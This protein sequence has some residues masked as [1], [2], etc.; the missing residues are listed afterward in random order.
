MT[1]TSAAN[2]LGLLVARTRA[3]G[4]AARD[5]GLAEIGHRLIAY[6]SEAAHS[7]IARAMEMAGLGRRQLRLVPV[8]TGHRIRVDTLHRMIAETGPRA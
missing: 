8:D 3:L 5:I 1:G 4:Q 7:C 6:T 2:F